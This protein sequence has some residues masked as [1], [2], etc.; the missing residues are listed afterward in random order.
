MH[1]L[2]TRPITRRLLAVI[3]LL[4]WPAR[5]ALRGYRWVRATS[6]EDITE[7]A[8]KS[9]L[10]LA[11]ESIVA[12]PS[13]A[14]LVMKAIAPGAYPTPDVVAG[15]IGWQLSRVI[16]IDAASLVIV[17][18]AVIAIQVEIVKRSIWLNV[19]RAFSPA[20]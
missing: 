4:T 13:L 6:V 20:P 1:S 15:E 11:G 14:L 3:C 18:L 17:G 8:K 12:A 19:C 16:G 5:A 7:K 9:R 2:H 10:I